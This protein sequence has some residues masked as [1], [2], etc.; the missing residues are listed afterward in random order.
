[1]PGIACAL[2]CQDLRHLLSEVLTAP[3]KL[4]AVLLQQH[5]LLRDVADQRRDMRTFGGWGLKFRGARNAI[6][7]V[8]EV[9]GRRGSCAVSV[10]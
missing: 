4:A 3:C 6:G 2:V 10:Q 9:L 1:M 5:N 8:M 7:R